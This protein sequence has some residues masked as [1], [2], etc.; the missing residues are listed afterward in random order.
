M[1]DSTSEKGKTICVMIGDISYDYTLELMNGINDAA[2]REG[3]Q[4][5]YMTGKQNHGIPVDPDKE[6][7]TISRYNSI[8]DY[9]SLI[10]ADAYIISCGSLSG[11]ESD[12][13]YQQFLKRFEGS[14]FVALQKDI[15]IDGP[16]KSSITIDNYSSCCQCI[17]HLIH[18]HGYKKIAFV[19]GPKVHPEAREREQAYRDTMKKHGL[20]VD[21][22]M[23]AY[24]DLSGFVD[25]QVEKLLLDHS[26]LDAIAFCNDEMA[27]A[28]YRVC[29]KSG[30]RIGKDIAITGFD[31]FTT[32][33]TMTP[34]LTTIS[35]D[36]YRTG[37]LALM[38]A[39]AL[40][41]GKHIE[42]VKLDTNLHI[43]NSCG[44]IHFGNIG[45][46]EDQVLDAE[47][48]LITMIE[49][50]RADL[51]CMYAQNGQEHLTVM[52]EELMEQISALTLADPSAALNEQA[53]DAWLSVY[54]SNLK[55]SGALIAER[56][57]IYLLQFQD[58]MAYPGMKKLFRILLYIQGFLFSYEIHESAKRFEYFRTQAWFVPEFIRELVVLED[59]V[60]GVFQYVVEQMRSIGL[61]NVYLCLLPEPQILRETNL[62]NIPK[63]L[64]LA[65]HLNESIPRAYPRSRMPVI[66]KHHPLHSLPNLKST[67]HLISFSVF[68]GDVQYGIILCE[69]DKEKIPLLH[70]IG[71]QLG[72][73]INFLDLK[74]KERV[75]GRELELIR[76]RIEILNFLSEYDSLCNV[77]NRRGFIER[78]IHMNRENLGKLASCVFMDLDHLKEIND[79]FGHSSGD[80]AICAVSDILKKMV[81]TNDLIARI[82]GDEFVGMFITDNPDF[83]AMFRARLK[84]AFEEYNRTSGKPYFVEASMGI[85]VFSCSQGLEISKIINE[86]DLYLYE[87]KKRKRFSALK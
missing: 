68:S 52:L 84:D 23:V 73:L 13:A 44:C 79:N 67:A 22:G 48:Y 72:I 51:F 83:Q 26:D 19:S 75:V 74:S 46:F 38:Q 55:N 87:D 61:D 77:Y 27:K 45:I 20:P 31:D 41:D 36:A 33:R 35:Q 71:L 50:M 14:A 64:L 56:L 70:V 39:V 10:G 16:R 47:E 62:S 3:V 40:A 80:D 9:A 58:N 4:L 42:S 49:N 81:R 54:A 29:T 18:V 21:V 1:A 69:A 78:A 6:N 60:E 37:E 11:F 28:G 43:R 66:D 12:V 57:N 65:A 34:P 85:A 63:R 30:L 5:F 17:E 86:A 53:L 59:E 82:G 76:E 15:N 7:E 25:A 24:G 32:G 2:E 8:Y